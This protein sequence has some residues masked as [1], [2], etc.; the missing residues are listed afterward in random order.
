MQHTSEQK[1]PGT[2]RLN[3]GRWSWAVRLPGETSRRTHALR[4]SPDSPALP[5]SVPR[6]IAESCARKMLLAAEGAHGHAPRNASGACTVAQAVARYVLAAAEYYAAGR[7]SETVEKPLRRL[8]EVYGGRPLAT[9]T[10]PDL[11]DVRDRMVAEGYAR[12]T[13]NHTISAWRC[14]ARWCQDSRLCSVATMQELVAIQALKSGR[15]RAPD[16]VPTEPVPH[17]A[18]KRAMRGAPPTLR[19]MVAVQELTGMRTGE[20]IAMRPCDI[21]RRD[22]VWLYR[23]A[24]HKNSWRGQAR[25]VILGPRAQHALAPYLGGAPDAPVWSPAAAEREWRTAKRAAARTPRRGELATERTDKRAPR[26][27]WDVH[28]Y[29]HAV[30]R[31]SKAAHRADERVP[32]W[33]PYQLR[34]ACGTRVR[35]WFGL[36]AA[37]AI[38]G[39]SMR[40]GVTDRYTYEAAEAETIRE[41]TR[42]A[43][44]LG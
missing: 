41:A 17:W 1:L 29:A 15:S 20:L 43:L 12:N 36:G 18:V 22:D 31:R 26:T 28:T 38:L 7:G 8:T 16:T 24:S 25:V 34:H 21:E 33:R 13:I 11:L 44:A 10:C 2:L 19:A 5:A 39:H 35:R 6:S 23:P 32:A 9:L 37:K 14:W 4:L 42:A 30:Q 40:A 3:R 27:A